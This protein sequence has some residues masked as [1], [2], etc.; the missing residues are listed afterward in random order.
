MGLPLIAT[1]ELEAVNTMLDFIDEQPV[2]TIGATISEASLAQATLHRISRS[3]Q[4]EGLNCNS[5]FNKEL[6]ADITGEFT[7][8]DH[9][10][11]VDA[12][13]KSRRVGY[14]GDKLYDLENATITFEPGE[15]IEVDWIEFL[16]FEDLPDHVRNYITLE[17][18]A[19]FIL[20]QT[21][22]TAVY[23]RLTRR[24]GQLNKAMILFKRIE[25][26]N[27]DFSML[28]SADTIQAVNRNFNPIN[29]HRGF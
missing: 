13:C 16:E 8:P 11:S 17:A 22:E 23:D 29:L 28:N 6:T 25:A 10:L 18:S 20:K 3:I 7:I 27:K 24:G 5:I 2:E 21:G 19:E 4:G 9:I 12:S 26:Q 15:K 14:R 1:T